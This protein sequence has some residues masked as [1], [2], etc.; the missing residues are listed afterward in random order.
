MSGQGGEE[1][2]QGLSTA[3]V[4]VLR[5][6]NKIEAIRLLREERGI[7]LKEAK[8]AVD[9]YIKSEPVISLSFWTG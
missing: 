6:G 1:L 7:G 5:Q 3:V 9:Q 8:E 2:K 4:A